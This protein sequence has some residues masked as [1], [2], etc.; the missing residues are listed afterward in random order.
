M[1]LHNCCAHA[2]EWTH[3]RNLDGR[4]SEW[5]AGWVQKQNNWLEK[6]IKRAALCISTIIN[7]E[8]AEMKMHLTW[9]SYSKPVS[10]GASSLSPPLSH[11]HSTITRFVTLDCGVLIVSQILSSPRAARGDRKSGC[12]EHMA[13]IACKLTVSQLAPEWSL[14]SWTGGE[15][16]PA[17]QWARFPVNQLSAQ[18]LLSHTH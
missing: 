4:V 8:A 1:P 2:P 16:L 11:L 15:A 9:I 7:Y 18:G 6:E 13:I 17:C 5:G 10:T 14:L 3:G 12:N